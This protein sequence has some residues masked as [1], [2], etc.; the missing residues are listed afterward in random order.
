ML[1]FGRPFGYCNR[2]STVHVTTRLQA[3]RHASVGA[4]P[5]RMFSTIVCPP[6]ILMHAS[7]RPV[8]PADPTSLSVYN[9]APMIGESPIRPGILKNRPL[10]VVTPE[11]LPLRSTAL[12]LMVPQGRTPSCESSMPCSPMRFGSESAS[13]LGV[14]PLS[15]SP[16]SA[17]CR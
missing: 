16:D 12:Q 15:S 7:P 4:I 14:N 3:S 8:E 2:F 9:P 10:V 1:K 13:M 6:Q 11:M 17:G 5:R